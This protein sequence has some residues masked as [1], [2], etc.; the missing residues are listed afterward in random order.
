MKKKITAAL[1]ALLM[2]LALASCEVRSHG[3]EQ[4]TRRVQDADTELSVD[5]F[6]ADE[7]EA[8]DTQKSAAEA[9]AVNA[10][11]ET[12]TT[13]AAK[14]AEPPKPTKLKTDVLSGHNFTADDFPAKTYSNKKLSKALN[15]IDDICADYGYTISFYYKNM[16]S[17]AECTYNADASYGVCSTVKAPFCK[18]LL[19]RGIDLDDEITI[20]VIWDDDDGKTAANG[21]GKT[22]SARELIR[23]AITQSDNTAYY[24][25]INYYGY[26]GFNNMNYELGVN[27]DLGYSWIFNYGTSRDL[28]KQYEDIYKY[29]EKSKRGKWLTELMQKTDLET[30]VTA[31]LADKYPVAHKYGS[32]W[33][34][35]CYHDC[36]IVYSDSPFVL[37]IMTDQVPETA[38]SDKVFKK[39]AKQFDIVNSQLVN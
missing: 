35:N 34:Q 21:Y 25:L 32:D 3:A 28:M 33:D 27:Y 11:A 24:N 4:F 23:R 1:T 16:D 5:S 8:A 19:E 39:L 7:S 20:E 12:T 29:A 2:A 13:T 38:K 36:A 17:G 22:Y 10:E 15:A 30:Q 37:V 9:D 14:P 6:G 26:D 18:E 31:E